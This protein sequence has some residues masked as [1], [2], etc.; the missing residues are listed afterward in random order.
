MI[1]LDTHVVIWLFKDRGKGLSTDARQLIETTDVI[2]ISPMVLLELDFLKE[3]QRITLGSRPVYD[4]LHDRLG[5]S[6][7][8]KPFSAVVQKAA[9][10][11]WTR[12]PFDRLITSQAALDQNILIT[13]DENIRKYYPH[14]TW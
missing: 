14:A 7:C 4:Y 5:L 12:D 11:S 13:K 6:I 2:F 10:Q 3:I 1:Y 8:E 9:E